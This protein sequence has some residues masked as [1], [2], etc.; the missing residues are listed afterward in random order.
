MAFITTKER[1]FHFPKIREMPVKMLYN[2][3]IGG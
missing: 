3:A 2:V 1:P